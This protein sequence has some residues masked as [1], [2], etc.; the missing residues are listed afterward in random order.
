MFIDSTLGT[1]KQD[2]TPWDVTR[3][4][5]TQFDFSFH[6]IFDNV[7]GGGLPASS[8]C[9]N[10]CRVP[11]T[12]NRANE[13]QS[14]SF[15]TSFA[16]PPCHRAGVSCAV[17]V[18]EAL[19]IQPLLGQVLLD[20]LQGRRGR[21][22][23]GRSSDALTLVGGSSDGR[24]WFGGFYS[25]L[26]FQKA[27]GVGHGDTRQLIHRNNVGNTDAFPSKRHRPTEPS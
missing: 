3:L 17:G 13:I 11:C 8:A 20:T 12:D 23:L 2:K 25:T 21:V 26:A 10:A 15:A 5:N 16:N 24:V 14:P 27:A 19:K 1:P 7:F 22:R 6:D 18:W 4:L 9:P